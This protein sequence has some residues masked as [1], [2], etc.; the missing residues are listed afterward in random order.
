[1]TEVISREYDGKVVLVTGAG[2]GI[3][4]A[5]ASAFASAGARVAVND[6]TPVN[7][8]T[9]VEILMSEG[10][11]VKDLVY[12]VA[13]RMQCQAMVDEIIATWGHLDILVNAAQVVPQ[14]VVLEM[15]EWDWRRTV[16]VNLSA[17]FFLCQAAGGV[18]RQ[19]G[20]GVILNLGI[21]EKSACDPAG[22]AAFL[23]SKLGV[24]GLTLAASRELDAYGIRLHALCLDPAAYT[25]WLTWL[26]SEGLSS[27]E[28]LEASLE[29]DRMLEKILVQALY[30]CSEAAAH[31]NG[32][33]I[34]LVN[35]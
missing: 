4:R 15:D 3:G 16:D 21:S 12:D 8:D 9:T 1:M 11:E 14:A 27:P 2:V 13:N 29:A 22:L 19:Q 30:L 17:A 7:L 33:V 25:A 34:D 6:L 18:M 32:Q 26:R 23:A 10:G 5:L 35:K 31:L 28:R 24:V 20:S